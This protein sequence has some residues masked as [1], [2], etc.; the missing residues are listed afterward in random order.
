[1]SKEVP[2]QIADVAKSRIHTLTH[3][4]GCLT[5]AGVRGIKEQKPP[6]VGQLETL[7][8]AEPQLFAQTV[9]KYADLTGRYNHLVQ[10]ES[11]HLALFPQLE[12]TQHILNHFAGRNT[13]PSLVELQKLPN[14]EQI[15]HN[16]VENAVQLMEVGSYIASKKDNL[17]VQR[18]QKWFAVEHIIAPSRSDIEPPVIHTAVV[19][20]IMERIYLAWLEEL[21]YKGKKEDIMKVFDAMVMYDR[22]REKTS[23]PKPT[24]DAD[25]TRLGWVKDEQFD[26]VKHNFKETLL[27][28]RKKGKVYFTS[29]D[30]R[31]LKRID[32]H[33]N[34]AHEKTKRDGFQLLL[35]VEFITQNGYTFCLHRCR[36]WRPKEQQYSDPYYILETVFKDETK[37]TAH[38]LTGEK[39]PNDET[40]NYILP[41]SRENV[42]DEWFLF[43]GTAGYQGRVRREFE[44]AGI[45][46]EQLM[47]SIN[48]IISG[49]NKETQSL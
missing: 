45:A 9:D 46:F 23:N 43:E 32:P 21:G 6:F 22:L 2:Q 3:R 7:F 24:L 35:P 37:T 25:F 34:L 29:S 1:M 26:G 31:E 30:E 16:G 18:I 39:L 38:P 42:E 17:I 27:E 14:W 44:S 13:L 12:E 4:P 48:E 40:I 41:R 28:E 47:K 33:V 8:A 49:N 11:P 5:L 20:H 36:S 15:L 19:G 10:F